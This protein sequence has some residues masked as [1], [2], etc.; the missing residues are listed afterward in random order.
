MVSPS[1]SFPLLRKRWQLLS[2]ATA[3]TLLAAGF[4]VLQTPA[5]AV[6]HKPSVPTSATATYK[7][8]LVTGDVVTVTTM[9]NGK[10]T[11]D[12]VRP[13]SALGGVRLQQIK[14]DTYVI[15]DEAAG[16]IAADKLDRQLFNVTDLIE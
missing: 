7:V 6:P 3:L 8:T 12:V 13:E 5:Q 10:Q 15:P 9:A 11:A 4:A 1:E 2:A 14:G 16:L